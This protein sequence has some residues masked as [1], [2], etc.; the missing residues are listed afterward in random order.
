MWLGHSQYLSP[1]YGTRLD[2]YVPPRSYSLPIR[3]FVAGDA[4]P[5]AGSS[6]VT[7][8]VA[9]PTG[10]H[11]SRLADSVYKFDPPIFSADFHCRQYSGVRQT[12]TGRISRRPSHIRPIMNSFEGA[13]KSR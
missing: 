11:I 2:G 9:V 1:A 8:G 3:R 4:P 12:S 13:E 7:A 5:G 10:R 6:P